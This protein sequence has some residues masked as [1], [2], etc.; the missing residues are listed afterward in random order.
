MTELQTS[1]KLL[2]EIESKRVEQEF[3]SYLIDTAGAV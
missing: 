3:I 1:S 2:R